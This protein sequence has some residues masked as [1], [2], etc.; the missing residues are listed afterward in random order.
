MEKVL[1]FFS[2]KYRG[3]WDRIYSALEQKESV[4]KSEVNTVK[5]MVTSDY[6]TII[7]SHFPSALKRCSNPPFVLYTLGN[8]ELLIN[9]DQTIGV[10]SGN[11]Y[12]NY[13]LEVIEK[14]VI[15]WIK[16]GCVLVFGNTMALNERLL[17]YV[18]KNQ[19]NVIII[20][21]EGLV[22]FKTKNKTLIDKFETHRLLIVSEFYQDQDPDYDNQALYYRLIVALGRRLVFVEL[23]KKE[24][25]F[26]IFNIALR[27]EKEIFS[28]PE[29]VGSIFDGSNAII[30][31]RGK[32][33]ESGDDVIPKPLYH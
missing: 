8:Q 5:E 31:R 17:T 22:S 32:L 10:V 15:D 7:D 33:V 18:A 29:P 20:A 30:K 19:G 25:N 4:L 27:E 3:N 26:E 11:K 23:T 16:K 6:L 28:V 21:N 2:L 9:Y 14:L 12:D 24:P 13:G 1:L